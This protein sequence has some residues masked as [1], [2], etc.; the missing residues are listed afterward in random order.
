MQTLKIDCIIPSMSTLM[1]SAMQMHKHIPYSHTHV[2]IGR[3]ADTYGNKTHV[4]MQKHACF[5]VYKLNMLTFN[6]YIVF[7]VLFNH[8]LLYV[9]TY[10]AIIRYHVSTLVSIYQAIKLQRHEMNTAG[11][12]HNVC[13]Q[14]HLHYIQVFKRFLSSLG[15]YHQIIGLKEF[16]VSNY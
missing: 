4:P 3:L 16:L 6:I 8:I 7:I 15:I 13:V 10:C 11:E 2:L 14:M 1:Q 9:F 12:G 5:E